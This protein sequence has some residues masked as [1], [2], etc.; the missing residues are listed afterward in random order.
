MVDLRSS[1]FPVH[2]AHQE[3]FRLLRRLRLLLVEALQLVVDLLRRFD[4][5]GGLQLAGV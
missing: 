4:A 2:N 1:G 5:I 3:S